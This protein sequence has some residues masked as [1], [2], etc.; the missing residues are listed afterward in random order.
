MANS[1]LGNIIYIDTAGS[2]STDRNTRIIGMIFT[3]AG[4]GDEVILRESSGGADKISIKHATDEDSK[5]IR[6]EQS[7]IIFGTGIYCQSIT[8]G[9]K[10]M[11][12]VS[13]NGG[14]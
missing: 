3:T 5:H 7:P 8:S 6:L 4:A 12:I 2:I 9:A 10:L 14:D 11:L 1:R 13:Q